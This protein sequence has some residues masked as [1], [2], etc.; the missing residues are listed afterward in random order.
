MSIQIFVEHLTKAVQEITQA[1]QVMVKVL[2]GMQDS[3]SDQEEEAT[4]DKAVHSLL[5]AAQNLIKTTGIDYGEIG[6]VAEP[7]EDDEDED[8]D[9]EDEEDE[10]DDT[11][12]VGQYTAEQ[13]AFYR[14]P[15]DSSIYVYFH[16]KE[17]STPKDMPTG[18]ALMQHLYEQT[19]VFSQYC[20]EYQDQSFEDL[21]DF[22]G[23]VSSYMDDGDVVVRLMFDEGFSLKEKTKFML[24]FMENIGQELKFEFMPYHTK[25]QLTDASALLIV[26]GA[27]TDDDAEDDGAD[28][29]DEDW[30]D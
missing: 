20:V 27:L 6:T 24:Q 18:E 8:D 9:D 30:E 15:D 25:A 26:S 23:M 13:F 1:E 7:D 16:V 5:D 4:V 17:N 2:E 29:D 28:D 11:S 22:E 10:D 14:E 21:E 19:L 12:M 3:P